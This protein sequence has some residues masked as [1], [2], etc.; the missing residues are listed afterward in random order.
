M[1]WRRRA[2]PCKSSRTE[3]L[4]GKLQQQRC[5]VS[6]T[7]YPGEPPSRLPPQPVLFKQLLKYRGTLYALDMDGCVWGLEPPGPD[8]PFEV[9]E[10]KWVKQSRRHPI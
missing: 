6:F 7:G 9:N 8:V 4:E 1:A 2:G 5:I 10:M 3:S